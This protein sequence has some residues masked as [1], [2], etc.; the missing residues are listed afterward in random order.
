MKTS[1]IKRFTDKIS[2]WIDRWSPVLVVTPWGKALGTCAED[3]Y[4]GLLKARRDN[5]KILFLLPY[6]LFWKLRMG[7]TNRELVSLESGPCELWGAGTWRFLGGWMLTIIFG[8]VR[9]AY[10]LWRKCFRVWRQMLPRFRLPAIDHWYMVPS[11]GRSTLWGPAGINH[12][13]KHLTDAERYR[14]E[15]KQFQPMRLTQKKCQRAEKLRVAMGLP[16]ADWFVCLHVRERGFRNDSQDPRNSS[17]ENYY[18]AIR[19]I[20][21]CGGW[22]VCLGDSSMS[23]M[24]PMDRVIDYAH[25]P[26]K[27]NLMDLYLISECRFVLASDSGPAIAA[28]LLFKKHVIYTNLP[29]CTIWG[30]MQKGDLIIPKHTFSRSRGRFLSVKEMLEEPVENGFSFRYSDDYIAYGNTADE[31]REV[32]EE[33][34]NRSAVWDFSALQMAFN[35]GRQLQVE[36]WLNTPPDDDESVEYK[37]RVASFLAVDESTVGQKYLKE[38][39]L[40]DGLNRQGISQ[41][42]RT[43]TF[44][45][46][47]GTIKAPSHQV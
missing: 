34:L 22:V 42:S 4:F 27:S 13:S 5:K 26:F 45:T 7:I 46:P 30:V 41:T 37:Y 15:A 20:T 28:M 43:D 11:V 39:W 16:L 33:Y 12:S 31:I 17:I 14:R 36:R 19:V 25:S 9:T 44:P 29:S 24:P 18:E 23:Q 10:L 35:R 2:D 21:R 8:A 1:L 32:V 38:N 47:G 40:A 6:E 3:I